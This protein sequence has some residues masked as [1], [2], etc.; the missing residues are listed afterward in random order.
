MEHFEASLDYEQRVSTSGKGVQSHL[1]T[2]TIIQM[3]RVEWSNVVNR[4]V[5]RFESEFSTCSKKV[6]KC[7]LHLLETR[8]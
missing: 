8:F 7:H 4:F 3:Q 1:L 2:Y 6:T 5:K